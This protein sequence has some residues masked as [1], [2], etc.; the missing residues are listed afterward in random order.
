MGERAGTRRDNSLFKKIQGK[1]NTTGRVWE[2]VQSR[3]RKGGQQV[4]A[5]DTS[6][7]K[8]EKGKGKALE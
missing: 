5:A 6:S 4:R 7:G 8:E 3:A 2:A 1:G